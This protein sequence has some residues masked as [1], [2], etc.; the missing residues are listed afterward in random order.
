[1]TCSSDGHKRIVLP[2][3]IYTQGRI[4][5]CNVAIV[6]KMFLSS[7]ALRYFSDSISSDMCPLGV[8]CRVLNWKQNSLRQPWIRASRFFLS[9]SDRKMPR[10]FRIQMRGSASTGTELHGEDNKR[11][12]SPA[13]ICGSRQR[14]W[15]RT[16]IRCRMLRDPVVLNI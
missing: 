13:S 14:R 16:R 15:I 3:I 6:W 8:E 7:T 1:M 5:K 10:A 12:S 4:P 2:V 9:A 11:H